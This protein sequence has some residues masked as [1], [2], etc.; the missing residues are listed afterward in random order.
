M[1]GFAWVRLGVVGF[2][3]VC[4]GSLGFAWVCLG[5]LGV[6]HRHMLGVSRIRSGNYNLIVVT[7]SFQTNS[8]C[9]AVFA[10]A[11]VMLQFQIICECR[12]QVM[13]EAMKPDLQFE[14]SI[15][16]SDLN[17]ATFTPPIIRSKSIL[18]F[19]LYWNNFCIA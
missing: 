17:S 4:L 6:A 8:V 9:K 3:W 11:L 16:L 10:I 15:L 12:N 19:I 1:L 7:R 5:S 2:A 18:V 14:V 13:Q